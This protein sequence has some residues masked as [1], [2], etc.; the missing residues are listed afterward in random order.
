MTAFRKQMLE[1]Q[2]LGQTCRPRDTAGD[3]LNSPS[4]LARCGR[5]VPAPGSPGPNLLNSLE[6]EPHPANDQSGRCAQ[7]EIAILLREAN[8]NFELP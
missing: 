4:Q 6:P 7:D 2:S 8:E 5:A 3:N 1:S